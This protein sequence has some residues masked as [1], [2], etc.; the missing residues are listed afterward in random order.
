[1]LRKSLIMD[2]KDSVAVLLEYAYKGD[3]ITT[4]LGEVV[5]LEDIEFAHKVAIRDLSAQALVY[6]YGHEIG[7]MENA[8]L[9]GT[10]IHNHNMKCDRG[11]KAG[12]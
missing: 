11:K 4:P 7:Y 3:S 8:I 6:K 1:V 12:C 2:P 5:L 10:W 9:K